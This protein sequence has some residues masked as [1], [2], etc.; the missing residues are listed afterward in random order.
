MAIKSEQD[1]EERLR[2]I[3]QLLA[4]EP[5]EDYSLENGLL[6]KRSGTKNAVVLPSSMCHDVIRKVHENG[7]FGVKKMKEAIQND[8]YI[9]KLKEKLEHYVECCV[10]CI[11]AEKKKSKKEGLL[12]PIP[13]GDAPLNTYHIDHLGPMASTSKL[14]KYLLVIVDGFSKFVWIYPTK[15]TNT[16]EVLDKL[17][18]MQQI[19]GNPQRII[20]DKGTAYTSSHFN[21]YCTA[22]NIAHVT[23]TTGVPRGNGQ[24]ERIH[25]IIIPVLT[26][27]SLDNPD[28]WYRHV[29]KL[30]MCINSTYQRSVDMSPFEALFGVK[31]RQRE[32]TQTLALIEQEY[33]RLYNQERD[34]LRNIAKQNILKVQAENQ[35]NY[36][37][38]RKKASIYKENDLVFIRRTQ[39]APGLKIKT[40]YLDPYRI[41]QVKG[42][43]RYE[44]VKIGAGEGPTITTSAA[45]YMKAYKRFPSGT[46]G[47]AGMAEC[48]NGSDACCLD[49]D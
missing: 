22:E 12:R 37:K 26:K 4:K 18:A 40:P 8:Y 5:Y 33:V 28:R 34:N 2:V 20:T 39:F 38:R 13:K 27:L 35:R 21:D 43:D 36:N 48:R 32:D 41:S 9:P 44:V 24:V 30:Q 11:L 10:P 17:T 47:E 49:S 15:T 3:K 6:V 42:N 16:K 23:I 29:S 45:D 14:Y 7:H 19:F 1:K 31:L 46:E 25:R